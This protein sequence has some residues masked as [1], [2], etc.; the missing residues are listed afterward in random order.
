MKRTLSIGIGSLLLAF[1]AQGATPQQ[2]AQIND[3]ISRMT[4]QE[5]VGQLNQLNGGG[6][7]DYMVNSIRGGVVGSLLNEVDP[8]TINT[9]QHEAVEH[10]RLGIPLIFARDVIHGFRTIFP[11]PLGQGATWNTELVR[12][13][14]RVA[15]DEASSVGIRWTFSPMVDIARDARWGRIAEGYGEDPLLTSRMGVAAVKGYQTDN[16]AAPNTMAACVKHFACYGAAES[17]RDYNTTWVP[18]PLLHDVYLPSFEASANAGAATFMCSFN[19]INGVPSSA[20]KHLLRDILREKWGW[21]GVVISDWNSI[22]EMINHGVAA[23][24][25]D[26]AAISSTAGVDIDMEGHAYIEQLADLVEKGEVPMSVLDEMVRNVLRLKMDLGLFDN[27]YIDMKSTN[28]FLT[29]DNL[30]AARRTAEESTILL[31]NENVL[32]LKKGQKILVTG[33][34]ADAKH[35][36]NGTWC[37]DLVKENTV[38]PLESLRKMYGKNVTYVAGLN[39]SR[40]RQEDQFDEVVKAA[41][42]ADV[43]IYFAGE[44]AVLS[45]EAHSRA[46]I[47]LPGAQSEY[48]RRLAATGKPVV[49]VVMTGRPMAIPEVSELSSALVY[50]FHPGTM[51]GPA[52]ANV[53]SG[54]VAP[55]GKLPVSLPT[56]SGQCPVYYAHKNTGRPTTEMVYIDDIPLEAGQTSTG[57]TSYFLDAGHEPLYPFGYGLSYTTF[58]YSAPTLSATEMSKDG[59]I[60]VTCTVKNTGKVKG[61]DV[62]QLYV[63]DLVASLAQPVKVLKDF[64]KFTLAPGESRTLTFTLPASALAFSD[65]EGNP[66]VEAGEFDLWVDNSSNCT[67]EPVKFYVK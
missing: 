42:K 24:K 1:L 48:L 64:E 19:D 58:E 11:I 43:I 60:T 51:G 15:A 29:K 31:K 7:A 50:S 23:D 28:R 37:F 40:D 41:A 10:S 35:D 16:L 22:T 63:H 54:V 56:M 2:E 4:L 5:K 67:K 65:L 30:D 25:R 59:E 55:G 49:T 45:G 46:D 6:T 14:C 53:L 20:N 66:V 21:K 12:E 44:E 27:P 3:L 38:T 32:P 17:G 62:A 13:G 36:Q 52:L 18:T 47:T 34:M 33:P 57:C 26:A 9:L 8:E 61:S 39:Y